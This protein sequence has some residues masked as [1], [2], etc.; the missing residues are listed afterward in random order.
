[1]WR[2]AFDGVG[3]FLNFHNLCGC[4]ITQ[5]RSDVGGVKYFVVSE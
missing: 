1:M 4:G 5:A 3:G 2:T